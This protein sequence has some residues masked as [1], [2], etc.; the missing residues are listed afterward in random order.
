MSVL[1]KILRLFVKT[2]TDDDKYSLLYRDN[3]TQ[4]IQIQLSQKQKT[5]SELFSPFSKSTLN[6]AHFLKKDD[7]IAVIIAKLPSP[8]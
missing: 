7:L 6:F 3:L 2:L 5:F 1:W 8:K 4:I